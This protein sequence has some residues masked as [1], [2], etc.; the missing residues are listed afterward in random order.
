M[1]RELPASIRL[2]CPGALCVAGVALLLG[3]GCASLS[4]KPDTQTA[5]TQSSA[6]P[7]TSSTQSNGSN[8]TTPAASKKKGSARLAKT[9]EDAVLRGDSAWRDGDADMAIYFYVQ[10]LSFKPRDF[11]T[12]CKLGSIEQKR[13][14]PTLAIRA[15]DLAANVN[16]ADERVTSR[17]GLLYLDQGEDDSARKWLQ[18]S[19]EATSADW[20][21]YDGLGVLES[22]H[23]DNAD[24]LRHLQ[25][26]IALAPSAPMPL[27]HD[28]QALSS[29][30]DYTGAEAALHSALRL[31][32]VPDAYR[33]LGQIQARRH[34]YS[35]ALNSYLRVLDPPEAYDT[36]AKL[37]MDN[38]DNAV[39]LRYFEQA[40]VLSPVYFE[41][42][43]RDA[44][45]VRERL[46]ASTR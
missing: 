1:S 8:A 7:I 31:G 6:D 39:A 19:A 43:H 45:V 18:H 44:E 29:Q 22:R 13:G 17:L 23:G 37:A 38:S 41:D 33:L 34:A 9:F 27:F 35:E 36:V 40:A 15:F 32:N 10:A 2:P 28:A 30:G 25:Q 26:A 24:A 5:S 12:L 21:V 46:A 20:R 16:P 14:N 11:D 4:S 3:A 42:A